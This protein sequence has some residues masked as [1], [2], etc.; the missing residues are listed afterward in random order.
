MGVTLSMPEPTV[1]VNVA[2]VP[3]RSPF[4]YPGGKTWLVPYA[5]VW[6]RSQPKPVEE[7]IESFAGGGIIG[8]TAACEGLVERVTLVELDPDIAAVWLTMLN[9][10]GE[11]LAEK[12]A[13]FNLNQKSVAAILNS[14]PGSTKERAF[15]TVIRNRVQRGGILA[16]GSG[17]IKKGEKGKGISSRW[18]PETLAE[19][20]VQRG[21]RFALTLYPNMGKM[22]CLLHINDVLRQIGK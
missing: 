16:P 7:L 8:L 17:L 19:T 10:G 6:L 21:L 1:V 11:W 18:Y 15:A 5:R 3:Q 9:G 22:G 2:S 20:I 4:R 12:I 13:S 14:H